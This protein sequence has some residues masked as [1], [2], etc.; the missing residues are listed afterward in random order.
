MRRPLIQWMADRSSGSVASTFTIGVIVTDS[1]Q[2]QQTSAGL[3]VEIVEG[4][5]C[6]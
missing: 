5:W 6:S 2:Q 3:G 4:W 1:Q